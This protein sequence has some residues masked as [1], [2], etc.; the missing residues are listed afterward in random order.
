VKYLGI[1]LFL[2][3]LASCSNQQQQNEQR[4]NR[5]Q[6]E[7]TLL[8]ANKQAVKVEDR[9]IEDYIR[10][11]EWKM[12]KTGTGLRYWIYESGNG[13]R[14]VQGNIVVL[15]YSVRLLNGDLIYTSEN[16]GF[17]EFEIGKGGVEAGLEEGI[18]LMGK[19]DRAK[20]ILP[21]HLAFGLTGDQN[22]I[23]PKATLIYDI[24]LL[25]IKS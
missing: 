1:I 25:K 10:R 5:K 24:K 18:L 15:E 14:P 21:S 7:E 6:I 11:K 12:Q 19:G 22:K 13:E 23:P 2:I 20:F 4:I 3:V 9:Q 17:K 16:L 8:E